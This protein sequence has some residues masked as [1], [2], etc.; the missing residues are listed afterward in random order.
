MEAL[1][2]IPD[3]VENGQTKMLEEQQTKKNRRERLQKNLKFKK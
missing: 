3:F 1:L 2:Q